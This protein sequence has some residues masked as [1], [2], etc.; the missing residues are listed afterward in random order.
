MAAANN[1]FPR[2]FL[3]ITGWDSHSTVCPLWQISTTVSMLPVVFHFWS[4]ITPPHFGHFFSKYC[5][6]RNQTQENFFHFLESYLQIHVQM[7]LSHHWITIFYHL[8]IASGDLNLHNHCYPHHH[9][10]YPFYHRQGRLA[11]VVRG[12]YRTC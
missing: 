3:L 12:L 1:R 5:S 9:P 10:V 2:G 6:N 8:V 11:V 4:M 7:T